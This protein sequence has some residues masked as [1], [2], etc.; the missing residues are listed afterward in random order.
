MLMGGPDSQINVTN[1]TCTSINGG[2]VN[3]PAPTWS[4][5]VAGDKAGDRVFTKDYI[6]FCYGNW[7]G[8][9]NIWN[10]TTVTNTGAW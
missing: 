2:R 9:S 8:V 10:R 6:Y 3:G 7:D 1:I 4:K 5:G